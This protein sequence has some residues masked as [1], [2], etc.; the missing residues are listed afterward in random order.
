MSANLLS[1]SLLL[2]W[3]VWCWQSCVVLWIHFWR[4]FCRSCFT[5]AQRWRQMGSFLSTCDVLSSSDCVSLSLDFSLSFWELCAWTLTW[6]MTSVAL[7]GDPTRRRLFLYDFISTGVLCPNVLS[8]YAFPMRPSSECFVWRFPAGKR[9]A[10]SFCWLS[11][12]WGV[13]CAILFIYLFLRPNHIRALVLSGSLFVS[14]LGI[15]EVFLFQPGERQFLVSAMIKPSLALLKDCWCFVSLVDFVSRGFTS[16]FLISIR[17]S[18]KIFRPTTGSRVSGSV[19]LIA[20]LCDF[21]PC[22]CIHLASYPLRY[23]WSA[24]LRHT[25][26]GGFSVDRQRD[27]KWGAYHFAVSFASIAIAP[28]FC[29]VVG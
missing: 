21:G 3:D 29:G 18:W 10:M 14:L 25:R 2:K 5:C 19:A 22:L 6:I 20:C 11:T 1:E 9:G 13:S 8:F 23:P 17:C 16:E 15:V 26:L 4:R 12:L 24:W 28:D 27:E 7:C